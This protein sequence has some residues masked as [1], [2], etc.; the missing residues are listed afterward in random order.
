MNNSNRKTAPVA[1]AL[2]AFLAIATNAAVLAG[3]IAP[4]RFDD[5]ARRA[6]L[7]QALPAIDALMALR[8]EE[9]KLPGLAYGVVIDGDLVL[10]KGVGLRD[11]E[12]KA[13]VN[14]STQFRIAS[15]TKS[16]TALAILKLRDAGKLSLDDPVS[17]HVPELASPALPTRDSQAITIRHLLT[18]GAGFPEDNPVGD[19]QMA[20][21]NA[22]FS[23]LLRGGIPFSNVPGMEFEYSNLGFAILG[24]IVSRVSGSPYRTYV[25]REILRP[26]G[27]E[28]TH[29]DARSAPVERLAIGYRRA[30]EGF[31]VVSLDDGGDS[32]FTAIG[33]LITSSRDLA[34]WIALMLS[35]FPP[36]DDPERAPALRRTLREMQ[37]G[38]RS[39]SLGV[40]R[41]NPGAPLRAIHV[42]AGYGL[43][44]YRECR[45]N[46]GVAH[47]GGLPGFGSHMRW[48]PQ[49]GVGVFAMANLTY[50]PMGRL[51]AEVLNLLHDTGALK[52]RVPSASPT[53]I[54]ATAA[55]ARVVDAWNDDAARA[56]AAPNFFLDESLEARRESAKNAREGL[57][58]CTP[59]PI[60]AENAL[61]GT[62]R[63]AC[64][65]GWIDVTLTLTPSRPPR[66]QHLSYVSGRPL[67]ENMKR[68]AAD[69]IGAMAKGAQDLRLAAGADRQVI[70]AM[71]ENARI[72]YGACRIGEVLDG[73]G[74]S[75]ARIRLACDRGD[76]VLSLR[77]QGENLAGLARARPS[78][79]AC[80]P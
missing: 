61:R 36:R 65:K 1:R 18:H 76:L 33:G 16:F 2:C 41:A 3:E 55:V 66:I 62:F 48:L 51:T 74:T 73:D 49:H 32:E 14:E 44:A 52:P 23:E 47:A 28:D 68:I 8:L 60:K 22:Q 39:T 45:F 30:D 20:L 43:F 26:L 38:S 71:L 21:S 78:D 19:R 57:G 79:A 42:S 54:Q 7:M 46:H 72:E 67:S 13:P 80:I 31:S 4:P 5:P 75:R 37:F 9:L 64:E 53:L 25:T 40:S 59:E 58:A 27:M 6:K 17:K 15:M 63:M 29:W 35:A 12:A 24:R 11:V 34:R 56:I 77:S 50:A 70:S 69:A 10:A